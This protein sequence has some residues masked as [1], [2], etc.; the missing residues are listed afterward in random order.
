MEYKQTLYKENAN[1]SYSGE[2]REEKELK[3]FLAIINYIDS[4]LLL[5]F[6]GPRK[7]IVCCM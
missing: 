3:I 4:I 7:T 6:T 1:L 5:I 2:W